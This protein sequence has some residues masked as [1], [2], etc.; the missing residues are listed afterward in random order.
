MQWL[1]SVLLGFILQPSNRKLFSILALALLGG[2]LVWLQDLPKSSPRTA[3]PQEHGEPDYYLEQAALKR[4][5]SE[6]RHFQT[7]EGEVV[8]HYPDSE[9]TQVTQPL[10]HHWTENQQLWIIRARQGEM[11]GE[12]KVFLEKDVRL[13]P[14]NPESAYTPE[15]LT[16]RLWLD[17]QE[18]TAETPDSVT[19]FSD[20]G[21]TQ[22]LGLFA[23]LDQGQVNLLEDVHSH[24]LTQLPA[25]EH[26]DQE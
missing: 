21:S 14:I 26:Q 22:G 7:L 23:T 19:F 4:Y 20:T 13:T 17:T 6:G 5:N 18:E 12:N 24:Y 11:R 3:L 15:F 8:T 1:K 9:L 16:Q 10:L 2:W 25:S